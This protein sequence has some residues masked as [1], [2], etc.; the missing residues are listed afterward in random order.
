MSRSDG[1]AMLLASGTTFSR[2]ARAFVSHITH[3][4]HICRSILWTALAKTALNSVNT[5]PTM[6]HGQ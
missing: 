3:D 2:L 6:K 4:S 1:I 5:T